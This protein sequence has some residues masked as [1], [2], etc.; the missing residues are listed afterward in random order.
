LAVADRAARG[1]AEQVLEACLGRAAVGTAEALRLE[2]HKAWCRG[3]SRSRRREARGAELLAPGRGD[4]VG[5]PPVGVV[6]LD[7]RLG[8]VGVGPEILERLPEARLVV[9]PLGPELCVH[10]VIHLFA[11]D[12]RR[13]ARDLWIS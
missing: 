1:R 3:L 6:D 12:L 13:E 2:L 5:R 7:G 8:A 9:Q 10:A 4:P 11:I